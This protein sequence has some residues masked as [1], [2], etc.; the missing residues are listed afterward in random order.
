MRKRAFIGS[1]K[2][3]YEICAIVKDKFLSVIKQECIIILICA[4][5]KACKNVNK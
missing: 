3:R 4:Y 5:S 1:L 2:T